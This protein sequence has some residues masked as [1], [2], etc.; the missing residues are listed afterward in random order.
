MVNESVDEFLVSG[1]KQNERSENDVDPD[2]SSKLGKRERE[3]KGGG[4]HEQ[5]EMSLIVQSYTLINP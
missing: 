4:I 3:K 5:D 1:H 2:L